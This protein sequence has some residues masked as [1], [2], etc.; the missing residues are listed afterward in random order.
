MGQIE[1]TVTADSCL[2]FML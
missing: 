2:S 1:S